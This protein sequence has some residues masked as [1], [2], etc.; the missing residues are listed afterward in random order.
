M[1][2]HSH[3][4]SLLAELSLTPR[5]QGRRLN[6][7]FTGAGVGRQLPH[8]FF[9]RTFED[10]ADFELFKMSQIAQLFHW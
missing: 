7:I 5:P 9:N 1:R 3:S 4:I 2:P 8:G 10:R 6:E